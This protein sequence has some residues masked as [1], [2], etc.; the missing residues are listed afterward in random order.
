MHLCVFEGI[1][2]TT[3]LQQGNANTWFMGEE[4]FPLLGLVFYFPDGAETDLLN[5][6]DR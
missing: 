1:N 5:S 6:M 4:L 2:L 3:V